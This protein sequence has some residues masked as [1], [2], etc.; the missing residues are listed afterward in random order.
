MPRPS[1]L[2]ALL[3]AVLRPSPAA[4]DS[5]AVLE[6]R[7]VNIPPALGQQIQ[8][9]VHQSLSETGG[10][11]VVT[12]AAAKERLA[13]EGSPAGCIIGPCLAGVGQTLRADRVLVGG[14]SG[15][16]TSYDVTL[17]LLETGG[18]M[19]LAQV[20][21]RCDVCNFME[22][23]RLVGAA[24]EKLHKQSL[25]F[26]ANHGVL[27]LTSEPPRAE[28]L[29]DGL[30]VG[31]TP[32]TRVLPPGR[33]TIEVATRG[34]AATTLRVALTPGKTRE[35][36]VTLSP[37]ATFRDVDDTGDQPLRR[38]PARW[39]KWVVLGAGVV[40]GGVGGSLL[41]LDGRETTD[42]RYVHDTKTGG[43]ALLSLGAAAAVAATLMSLV[44][45]LGPRSDR[46]GDAP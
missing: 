36:R 37:A 30:P 4:A 12:E 7:F 9:Q 29:L 45:G 39:V 27:V 17:T 16:G 25:V 10:Y 41:A 32:M 33:H 13:A 3:F 46:A 14:I 42:P 44:E 2:L 26:L 21:E 11:R 1:V 5:V 35:V 22:A 24:T 31:M 40:A 43:V 34:F 19:V 38:R 15:Q 28:V 20:S 23:V 6:L 8:D 18:G